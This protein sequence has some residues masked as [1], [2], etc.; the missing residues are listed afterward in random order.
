LIYVDKIGA[1]GECVTQQELVKITI[2]N[3]E[4]LKEIQKSRANEGLK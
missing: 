2:E 1:K 4:K 3:S